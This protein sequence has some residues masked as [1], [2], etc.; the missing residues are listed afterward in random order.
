LRLPGAAAAAAI[1]LGFNFEE[2]VMVKCALFSFIDSHNADDADD[3]A[4][5]NADTMS[6]FIAFACPSCTARFVLLLI[7]CVIDGASCSTANGDR[8]CFRL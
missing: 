3:D 1:G 5:D 8:R 7:V 4:D 2:D 6:L